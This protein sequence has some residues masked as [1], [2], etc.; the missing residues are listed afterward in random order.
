MFRTGPLSIIRI[1]STPYTRNRYL[2]FQF[3]WLY[4]SVVRMT[5]LTYSQQNQHVLRVYGGKIL[6]MMDSGHVRNMQ[7]TLSNKFEKQCIRMTTLTDSQQNQHVLRVYGGKIL[8]MKGS[9]PV[10]NIQGTLS[11]KY[12]KWC[13]QL[14]FIIRI[15]TTCSNTNNKIVPL[16]SLNKHLYSGKS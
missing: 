10:R 15:C 9:G 12:E 16:T 4:V 5:T 2:L 6:L 1:I 11:N 7:N 13:I 3:C 8:L 14:A